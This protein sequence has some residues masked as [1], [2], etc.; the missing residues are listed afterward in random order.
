MAR[1]YINRKIKHENE[2][3]NTKN[4][5]NAIEDLNQNL[6]IQEVAEV[7]ERDLFLNDEPEKPKTHWERTKEETR[8]AMDRAGNTSQYMKYVNDHFTKQHSKINEIKRLHAK[9]DEEI[10][11]LKN[12][13]G[14][15]PNDNLIK[16][17]TENIQNLIKAKN[18]LLKEKNITRTFL[19]ELKNE[20]LKAEKNLENIENQIQKIDDNL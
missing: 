20:V 13:S 10:N 17:E 15:D 5:W 18:S 11:L 8:N 3:D 4:D 6:K 1:K 7:E 16:Y 2:T 14:N 12:G 9:F 19:N